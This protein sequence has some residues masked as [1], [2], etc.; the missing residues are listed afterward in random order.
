MTRRAPVSFKTLLCVFHHL[1]DLS[2]AVVRPYFRKAITID[3]KAAGGKPPAWSRL[4]TRAPSASLPRRSP[5]NSLTSMASWARNMAPAARLARCAGSSIPLTA[6][7]PSS[8]VT[9]VGHWIGLLDGETPILGLMDQPFTG[10]K[11]KGRRPDGPS[12][13]CRRQNT[14]N[15]DARMSQAR[16]CRAHHNPSGPVRARRRGGWLCP[17]Q[18]R[19]AHD[20]LW[21]RLLFV[22]PVNWPPA[23]STSSSSA[24]LSPM[25]SWRCC[26]SWNAPVR[27]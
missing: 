24:D 21:R 4:R 25:T 1:A 3:N 12:A 27:P 2:G 23:S 5:N 19:G 16:G 10:E 8:W 17:R 13:H 9:D 15:Q 6:R 11:G 14:R 18:S 7:A 20:A 26:Q 22:L